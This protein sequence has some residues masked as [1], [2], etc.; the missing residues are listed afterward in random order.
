M[1]RLWTVV[2]SLTML[3]ITFR[4]QL[5]WINTRFYGEGQNGVRFST[6]IAV[7]F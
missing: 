7:H 3:T 6:G 4:G 2:L 1:R 5:D